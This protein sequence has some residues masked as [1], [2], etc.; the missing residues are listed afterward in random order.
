MK[1]LLQYVGKLTLTPVK[2]TAQD[3][4]AVLAAGWEGKALHDAMAVFGLFNLV[5]RLGEGLGITAGEDYFTAAA[6]RLA[7]MGYTGLKD[8]L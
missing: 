5:N 8:L 2:I 7:E 6:G 1:P 4:E 3:A